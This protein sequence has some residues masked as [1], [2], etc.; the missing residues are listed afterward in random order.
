[1]SFVLIA[2]SKIVFLKVLLISEIT[3]KEPS[4]LFKN[5]FLKLSIFS[6]SFISCILTPIVI[7]L[8]IYLSTLFFINLIKCRSVSLVNIF[9]RISMND[10]PYK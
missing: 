8:L 10:N 9:S 4:C 2:V 5:D 1:M 3:F 6:T 7:Y